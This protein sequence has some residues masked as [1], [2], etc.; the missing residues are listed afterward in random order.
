MAIDRRHMIAFPFHTASP[1][2]RYNQSSGS[3]KLMES[4]AFLFLLIDS[5]SRKHIFLVTLRRGYRL[6]YL[7][8]VNLTA[9]VNKRNRKAAVRLTVLRL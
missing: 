7:R 9:A 4:H 6:C 2:H 8:T 5:G 3:D 1:V